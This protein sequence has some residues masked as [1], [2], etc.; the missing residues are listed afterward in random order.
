MAGPGPQ[1]P[2]EP[3]RHLVQSRSVRPVQPWRGVRLPRLQHHLAGEQQL[4]TTQH[5]L[6]GRQPLG[7]VGVVPAPPG[8]QSPD[9]TLGEA[10]TVKAIW[11]AQNTVPVDEEKAQSLMKLIDSL[12]D[13]D[14][15]QAVYSNFEVS[16]D[17]M[18]KL[19]AA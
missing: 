16:D 14:D 4:T 3:V 17:V 1:E 12:E 13:D 8:V 6:A 9:L 7:I 2:M 10:E 11:K 5:L 19:T 18:A 15:V